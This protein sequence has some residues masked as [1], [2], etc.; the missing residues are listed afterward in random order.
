MIL[1]AAKRAQLV[2]NVFAF[3]HVN[4]TFM[5]LIKKKKVSNAARIGKGT[6][7]TLPIACQRDL[8][9]RARAKR[10]YGAGLELCVPVHS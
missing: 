3:G 10:S 8:R 9:T 6:L 1:L 5:C 4:A 2:S 7:H